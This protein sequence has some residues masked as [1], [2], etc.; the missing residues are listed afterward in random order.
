MNQYQNTALGQVY[1]TDSTSCNLTNT[2]GQTTWGNSLQYYDSSQL[3]KY[4][5]IGQKETTVSITEPKIKKEKKMAIDK[6]KRG[7]FQVILIDPKEKKMLLD[8]I[9]IADNVEDV[10]LEVD[11]GSI[12]KNAGLAVSDVDKIVNII[13][14]IRK[15]RKNKNG[16]VEIINEEVKE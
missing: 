16:E 15:T 11:A 4:N 1:V 8:K 2:L 10:L 5:T 12:I 3:N 6:N 13:G 9:V 14:Q 7:L